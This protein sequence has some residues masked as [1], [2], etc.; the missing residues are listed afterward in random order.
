VV[1]RNFFKTTAVYFKALNFKLYY[2]LI[3]TNRQTL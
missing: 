1:F 3:S 2:F